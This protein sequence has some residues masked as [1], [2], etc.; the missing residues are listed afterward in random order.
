MVCPDQQEGTSFLEQAQ[1]SQV[2]V[3]S[4]GSQRTF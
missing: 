2:A 3:G 4:G 1:R